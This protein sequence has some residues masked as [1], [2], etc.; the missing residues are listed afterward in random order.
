MKVRRWNEKGA[1]SV[2]A[3]KQ[4]LYDE[5]RGKC[6]LC[7]GAVRVVDGDVEHDIP[8]SVPGAGRNDITNLRFACRACNSLKGSQ[9]MLDFALNTFNSPPGHMSRD[10]LIWIIRQHRNPGYPSGMVARA[11]AACDT[12]AE[13][14]V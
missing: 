3:Y 5:Q 2:R 12:A 4:R 11:E 7:D 13:A 1:R 9:T 14:A 10:R 8:L 6:Y